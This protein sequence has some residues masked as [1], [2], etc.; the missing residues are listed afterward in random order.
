MP[1]SAAPSRFPPGY[2]RR[3]FRWTCSDD[4]VVELAE[5]VIVT[6]TGTNNLGATIAPVNHT[7]TVTIAD[8]D[9]GTVSIARVDDGAE[10]ATPAPGKFR[11]TQSQVSS[12][13][14]VLNYSV[15]GTATPGAGQDYTPLAGTVTIPAGATSADIDV[16]VL[17][18][19]VVEATETVTVTLDGIT[20]NAP[21][22]T[23]DDANKTA[24]VS[25]ADDD[26]ATI[27]VAKISD[28]AEAAT[29][30]NGKFQVTQSQPSSTDTVLTYTVEGTATPGAGNDYAPLSGTVTIAA[31]TTTAD[32]DMA[33]LND[34]LVETNETVIVT[35]AGITSGDPQ[36]AID[37]ASKTAT[38]SIGD[39]DT[40]TVSIAKISDGAES[41]TPTDGKFRVTQTLTSATDTV[42]SY[43]VSGTATPGAG[44]DY[45]PLSGTVT[46]AAGATTADIDI[47]VLNDDLVEGGETVLVTLNAVTSG[48]AEIAIDDLH[49]TAT[50]SISDDDAAAVSVA[51]VADGAEAATPAP[52]KFRVTQTQASAVD[53]VLSYTVSGTATAGDGNDFTPLSGTVTVAAGSLTADIDVAV[54]D[55]D[56]VEGAE[57]VSVTLTAITSDSPD[58]SINTAAR[59]ASLDILDDDA[60]SVSLARVNDG[61]EAATPANGRFRVSQ[62]K[63]STTDTVLSY[64]VAGT[65]TPGDAADY[66]TL[67]GTVTIAA[68]AT[69][70]DIV[71]PV[72]NDLLV[73]QTETVVVTL[74]AV[75]SGD[76]DIDIDQ[77]NKTA[78]VSIL[79]EITA[80]S[81]E[82]GDAAASEPVPTKGS[83]GSSWR[84][85]GRPPWAES[86]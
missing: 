64:L 29:P 48:D 16:S 28:G 26:T 80:V 12:T 41:A 74:F 49:R 72:L 73:E 11:V 54:L 83:S 76:P 33:V 50:L 82:A 39:D 44:K 62:T 79:D 27:S 8:D 30:T 2:R 46:I 10:G 35:L 63:A 81:I 65:A 68:G 20:G 45:T 52:G 42:L 51:K 5:S 17:D 18:D 9:T 53:T 57:T 84:A 58:V 32:I 1:R 3:R 69:S 13:D 66:T 67:A 78:T 14:T 6:L 25:I 31:G 24:T 86:R 59:A 21:G 55:D 60:A 71:V 47:A 36:V 15:N 4:S 85:S 23:I 40:A 75:T 38:V 7:A 43:T 61:A 56:L 34:I 19:N 37:D 22:I 77:A 70:A